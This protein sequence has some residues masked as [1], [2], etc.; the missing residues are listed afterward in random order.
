MPRK[1]RGDVFILVLCSNHAGLNLGVV[2]AAL[3]AV[4]GQWVSASILVVLL[5]RRKLMNVSDMMPLPSY[6]E[7]APYI[8]DGTVL[9]FRMVVTFGESQCCFGLKLKTA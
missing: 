4:I 8:F 1:A 3:A 7:V 6:A 9:A 2:G 5:V